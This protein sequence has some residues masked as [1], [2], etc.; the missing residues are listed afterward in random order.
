[1]RRN[2]DCLP[3]VANN[4]E[5]II[6]SR[7]VFRAGRQSR[8]ARW[9][10]YRIRFQS[11]VVYGQ[12]HQRRNNYYF[13]SHA[14][15]SRILRRGNY[16]PRFCLEII[17]IC[18]FSTV[19]KINVEKLSLSIIRNNDKHF[20]PLDSSFKLLFKISVTHREIDI[21][22]PK[23]SKWFDFRWCF[24]LSSTIHVDLLPFDIS[25][26]YSSLPNCN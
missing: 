16:S 21:F 23:I 26:F 6:S 20:I 15:N 18:H 1:M 8:A 19:T 5:T 13:R 4:G 22:L 11:V 12:T 7:S 14:T 24:L 2:D 3:F 9:N 25:H 10:N 17:S